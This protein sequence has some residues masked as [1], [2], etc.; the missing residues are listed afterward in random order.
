MDGR[1]FDGPSDLQQ[2]I[3]DGGI[4]EIDWD[5]RNGNNTGILST[6]VDVCNM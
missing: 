1:V 4:D 6:Q 5:N 3:S 2:K